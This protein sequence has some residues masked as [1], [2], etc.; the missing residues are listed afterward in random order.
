MGDKEI[1]GAMSSKRRFKL[2]ILCLIRLLFKLKS[3]TKKNAFL[4]LE[5]LKIPLSFND[6]LGCT[7]AK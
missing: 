3:K 5:P 2:R 4:L 7:P 1:G 6:S